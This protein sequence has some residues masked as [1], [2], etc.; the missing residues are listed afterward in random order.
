MNIVISTQLYESRMKI[1]YLE[2][3]ITFLSRVMLQT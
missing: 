1:E 2:L 3:P